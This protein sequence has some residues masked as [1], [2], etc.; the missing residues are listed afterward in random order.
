MA[1]KESWEV[2]MD[3]CQEK[4]LCTT[5]GIKFIP[6]PEYEARDKDFYK[7]LFSTATMKKFKASLKQFQLE[8]DE[9]RDDG[10]LWVTIKGPKKET[11]ATP[12]QFFNKEEK[13]FVGGD[14]PHDLKLARQAVSIYFTSV[15]EKD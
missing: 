15:I 12:H 4:A 8:E 13:K 1:K 7:W 3:I 9:E 2:V 6:P 14:H 10:I 5:G 11:N